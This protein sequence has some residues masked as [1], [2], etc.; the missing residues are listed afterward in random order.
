MKEIHVAPTQFEL[1]PGGTR[2]LKVVATFSDSSTRDVTSLTLYQS[3]EKDL[4]AVDEAGKLTAAQ[5][6]G[7]AVIV[8]NYMGAVDVARPVLPPAKKLSPQ[9]FDNQPVFNDADRLIYKRLQSVGAAP[10][11]QCS[12]AQFIRRS[13]LIAS[14]GCQR[15]RRR[16]RFMRIGQQKSE[17]GGSRNFSRTR[18]MPTTGR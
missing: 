10:S 18:T 2:Q 3:N 5:G 12:D 6:T 16:E 9:Y 14:E 15:S 1:L 7:E 11:G 4:V 17:S 8:V 13:A